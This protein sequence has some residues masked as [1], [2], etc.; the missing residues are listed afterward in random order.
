MRHEKRLLV[1]ICLMAALAGCTRQ[2][3]AQGPGDFPRDEK[4]VKVDPSKYEKLVKVEKANEEPTGKPKYAATCVTAARCLEQVGDKVDNDPAFRK[5]R[6]EQARREY[7]RALEIEPKCLPA[8]FG[9]ARLHDKQGQYDQAVKAYQRCLKQDANAAAIW[10][11]FGMCWGRQKQWNQAVECMHKAATLDP[12]NTSYANHVGFALARAE[13]Y[14]DSLAYFT[15]TVGEAQA[16]LNVAM[17]AERLGRK[18]LCRHCL[19]AAL[20]INPE[21]AEARQLLAKLDGEEAPIQRT[22]HGEETQ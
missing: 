6:Y 10:F 13:R 9:L 18:D 14:S 11:E 17:M 1:S 16:N 12:T 15:R 19:H 5:L 8:M 3:T 22:S 21:M 4:L 20:Q 2:Q 7:D